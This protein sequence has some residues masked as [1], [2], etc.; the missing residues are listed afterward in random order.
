[1]IRHSKEF[2]LRGVGRSCFSRGIG[3]VGEARTLLV[4]VSQELRPQDMERC[5]WEAAHPPPLVLSGHA[6]SLTR[7]NRTRR[8]PHPV[9]IGHAVGGRAPVDKSPHGVRLEA[10]CGACALDAL[11][12]RRGRGV[13]SSVNAQSGPPRGALGDLRRASVRTAR[14]KNGGK[15]AGSAAGCD[16][17]APRL[18]RRRAQESPRGVNLV[19]RGG[20]A[21][22]GVRP[23]SGFERPRP[24]RGAVDARGRLRRGQAGR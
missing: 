11:R 15:T 21:S 3:R 24:V 6:A 8:V 13:N 4:H 7:T 20:P 1:M 18:A 23:A 2:L 12:A 5:G 17:G 9:L 10:G 22:G 14:A 16:A 19:A